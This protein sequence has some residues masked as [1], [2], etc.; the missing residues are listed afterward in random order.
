MAIPQLFG[1]PVEFSDHAQPKI[2]QLRLHPMDGA[3]LAGTT[4]IIEVPVLLDRWNDAL[5]D[6]VYAARL[7]LSPGDQINGCFILPHTA[8]APLRLAG[9]VVAPSN[10]KTMAELTD[11]SK[12]LSDAFKAAGYEFSCSF[13]KRN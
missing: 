9:F 13:Y 10:P 11:A 3:G 1:Y 5:L 2:V 6:A 7:K 12:E 8:Y 4:F